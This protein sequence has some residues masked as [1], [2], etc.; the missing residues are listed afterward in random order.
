[1]LRILLAAVALSAA[2]QSPPAHTPGKWRSELTFCLQDTRSPAHEC[3]HGVSNNS[4]DRLSDCQADTTMAAKSLKKNSDKQ[5]LRITAL[6]G[7]CRFE[8]AAEGSI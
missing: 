5:H 4:F 2:P 8:D 6:S 3:L 7:G 1:M